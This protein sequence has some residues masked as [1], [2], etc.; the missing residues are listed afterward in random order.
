M[1]D[2]KRLEDYLGASLASSALGDTPPGLSDAVRYAV[3]PG[4]AR[5]R[6]RLVMAVALA[7]GDDQ[8]GLTDAA[9]AAIEMLHCASL[10]HDDLPAFDGASLRR[11]KP[12]VHATF[13]QPLAIL[14]GDALIVHAFKL[15]G[16]AGVQA[17]DRLPALL[18]IV[19]GGVGMPG[20]I[21]AGQAWECE[22][23]VDLSQYQQAKTGALFAAATM[24]G[25]AAAG[26][27][28]TPWRTLG[29]CIGE[30]YQVADD[31]LD[32]SGDALTVGKPVG[33]D[34]SHDRPNAV[35]QL[36]RGK[37]TQRLRSL[38]DEALESIPACPGEA[39]LRTL[40]GQ[41]SEQFMKLALSRPAAA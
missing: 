34:Q 1:I 17:P 38:V 29:Q 19:A 10:V 30:A 20:G 31:L 15:L 22:K 3:F 35:Q 28:P 25:A 21:V 4:G 37:C 11:G 12:S 18:G 26:V 9:A 27:D 16:L 7:N 6:P 36:G 13:G 39:P 5:V 23:N 14:T 41:E 8:P 2:P 32:T 24:A 33:Q 40:I